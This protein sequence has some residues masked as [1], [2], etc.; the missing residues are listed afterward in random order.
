M[1]ILGPGT[2]FEQQFQQ[3]WGRGSNL[4]ICSD[5]NYWDWILNPLSIAGF[6]VM[7]F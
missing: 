7:T 2:E 1:E 4:N 3:C 6:S 5:P